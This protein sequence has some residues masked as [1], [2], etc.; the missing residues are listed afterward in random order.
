MKKTKEKIAFK[1]IFYRF[2]SK[3]SSKYY[4]QSLA[5]KDD[6]FEKIDYI[7]YMYVK[8]LNFTFER[9]SKIQKVAMATVPPDP[10]GGAKRDF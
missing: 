6:V 7:S 9:F 3:H 10:A 2:V 4:S 8:C 5:S 1:S